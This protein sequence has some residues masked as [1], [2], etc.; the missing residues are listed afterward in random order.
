MLTM[1]KYLALAIG[2]LYCES[3]IR[4]AEIEFAE[5][6]KYVNLEELKHK[7]YEELSYMKE[8]ITQLDIEVKEKYI[9]ITEL[10]SRLDNSS[11]I[12]DFKHFLEV[13]KLIKGKVLGEE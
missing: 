13:A 2:L 12:G 8:K 10:E 6:K 5:F 11:E 1:I 7:C 9:L 4:K 3:Q